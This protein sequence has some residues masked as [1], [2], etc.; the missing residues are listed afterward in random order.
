VSPTQVDRDNA[1]IRANL[2]L[3]RKE[4]HAAIE[5]RFDF[6]LRTAFGMTEIG[7]GLYTPLAASEM[8]GSGSCGIPGPFREA[9]IADLNGNTVSAGQDG[10]LLFRGPGLLQAYWRKPDATQAAFHGDWFRSGDLA[11][12]DSR[13]FVTIVGRIKEM[14]RRAGENISATEVE[15]VL[16]AL[17]GVA[18]AAAVPVPDAQRGEEVKAYLVLQ[19]GITQTGLT[20]ERVI[21]HCRTQLA[22]FKVPRYIEYRSTP[23]PR[24]TSGKVQKPTLLAETDD[25]RC[26]SWDR[27]AGAA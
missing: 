10:E 18:E 5:R 20:P 15:S 4:L 17:P 22:S 14:I 27:L 8:T 13:G 6:P 19:E 25:L 23:L 24:S 26:N 21:A 2:S 16:L 7:M 11:R 1:M 3:H 12:Q 9:R